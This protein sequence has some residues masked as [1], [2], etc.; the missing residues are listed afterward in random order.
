M[1]LGVLGF[2]GCRVLRRSTSAGDSQGKHS[3]R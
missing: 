2:R 1:G 3:A